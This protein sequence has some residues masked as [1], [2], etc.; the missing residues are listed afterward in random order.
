M[1]IF[2]YLLQK[3]YFGKHLMYF[4]KFVLEKHIIYF[5]KVILKVLLWK[6]CFFFFE[7]GNIKDTLET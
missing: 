7:I 5:K 4:E 3:T 2:K 6:T 1:C